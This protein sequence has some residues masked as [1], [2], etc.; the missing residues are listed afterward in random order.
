MDYFSETSSHETCACKKVKVRL[1][2]ASE[3]G[4]NTKA[5]DPT[6][7]RFFIPDICM[8]SNTSS[9]C[10]VY[11]ERFH[12]SRDSLLYDANQDQA[13]VGE[14][15]VADSYVSA[16]LQC[17]QWRTP[18]SWSSLAEGPTN[19][20]AVTS[21]SAS[22]GSNHTSFVPM[23]PVELSTTEVLNSHLD[24]TVK[25]LFE[26]GLFAGQTST[27]IPLNTTWFASICVEIT[28]RPS[29]KDSQ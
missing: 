6:T 1:D 12:L 9:K 2:L 23:A 24:F 29:S 3:S 19:I 10:K 22:Q 15:Q 21:N 5:S 16:F 26:A 20:I 27:L 17:E 13:L 8:L 18:Y 25:G 28:Q 4:T 7:K 11:V 14:Q